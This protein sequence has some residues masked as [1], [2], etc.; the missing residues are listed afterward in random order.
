MIIP[1]IVNTKTVYYSI[2]LFRYRNQYGRT[3]KAV[4]PGLEKALKVF[5]DIA[6]TN[7]YYSVILRENTVYLRNAANEISVSSPIAKYE[8]NYDFADLITDME[9][10][11]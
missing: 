5:M 2:T 10:K 7:Q 1:E 4:Y 3:L 6:K 11:A 8:N 9:G